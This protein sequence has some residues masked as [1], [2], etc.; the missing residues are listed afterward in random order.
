M[1]LDIQSLFGL[2]V[3]NCTHWLDPAGPCT[4]W[5]DP[6]VQFT[7]SKKLFSAGIEVTATLPNFDRQKDLLMWMLLFSYI[8]LT[9]DKFSFNKE[10]CLQII[11]R[12]LSYRYTNSVSWQRKI[13][14]AIFSP[15]YIMWL[16][17]FLGKYSRKKM[18]NLRSKCCRTPGL[19]ICRIKQSW[20]HYLFIPKLRTMNL[21]LWPMI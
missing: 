11:S 3:H 14:A 20:A 19:N 9:S 16:L 8:S 7:I 17:S 5:L 1:E 15:F 13:L 18:S 4:H 10:N 21:K 12:H 2:Y 6:A